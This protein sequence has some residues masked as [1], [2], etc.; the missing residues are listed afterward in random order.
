M[1]R[2]LRADFDASIQNLN[3]LLA[4][5]KCKASEFVNDKELHRA[6]ASQ[7]ALAKFSRPSKNI[8]ALSLNT[9]KRRS[10]ALFAYGFPGLDSERRQAKEAIERELKRAAR[11]GKRTKEALTNENRDLR[12]EVIECR[13]E[14]AK[15]SGALYESIRYGRICAEQSQNPA[16]AIQYEKH[17]NE[18]LARFSLPRQNRGSSE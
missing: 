11:M 9:L 10:D 1:A 13:K 7:G 12:T 6:L 16:S 18:L 15:L 5:A 17:I 4:D 3:R 14:L 8:I 2:P